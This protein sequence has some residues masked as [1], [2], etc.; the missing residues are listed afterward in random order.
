LHLG[1]LPCDL[2]LVLNLWRR[3]CCCLAISI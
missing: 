2:P 3:C 1:S